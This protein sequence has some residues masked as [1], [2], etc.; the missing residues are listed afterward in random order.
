MTPLHR[1]IEVR[2][3]RGLA[4][5]Q[6]LHRHELQEAGSARKAA[7]ED[8]DAQLERIAQ[9]LPGALQAGLT[10][11]E[12]SRITGVSRQTVYDLQKRK[13]SPDR[14]FAILSALA[15]ESPQPVSA[16]AEDADQAVAGRELI[17]RLAA[18]GLVDLGHDAAGVETASLT[19]D[20]E[21]TLGAWEFGSFEGR[22]TRPLRVALDVLRFTP[23]ERAEFESKIAAAEAA[24]TTRLGLLES[25]RIGV[26]ASID[27]LT[28]SGAREE[29]STGEG[30]S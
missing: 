22:I 18:Q 4:L 13:T 29:K 28:G 1:D 9:H 2:R 3:A 19:P 7:L 6:T 30:A 27:D 17:D 10:V 5:V 11:A 15:G 24:G 8:A 14:R 26:K 12:V 20:G 25:L 21:D 16:L 23:E